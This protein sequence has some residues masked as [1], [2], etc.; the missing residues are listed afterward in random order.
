M[1][2]IKLATCQLLG[3]HKYSSSYRNYIVI[4]DD[5]Q[6]Y[7]HYTDCECMDGLLHLEGICQ[8]P[9]AVPLTAIRQWPVY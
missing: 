2:Q 3:T 8:F 6:L 7:T 5:M 1:G 9:F 4:P